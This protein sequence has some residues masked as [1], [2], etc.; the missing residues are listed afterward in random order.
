VDGSGNPINIFIEADASKSNFVVV[1]PP[2][3]AAKGT[4]RNR[5]PPASFS[6]AAR[7]T[8]FSTKAH[9][10]VDLPF[11]YSLPKMARSRAGIPP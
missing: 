6:M 7:Q 3:F 10:P 8:S 2:G 5:R 11:L 9:L 1:P 4:E